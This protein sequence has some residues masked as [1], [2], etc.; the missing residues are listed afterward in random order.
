[1]YLGKM[2]ELADAKTIY[3]RPM[4]PYSKSLLS[5]VPIPDPKIA[6]A[7]KRIMLEGDIPSP[8]NSP[9]GCPFRTRCAYATEKCAAEVPPFNEVEKGHFVA[10]H[11]VT[12]LN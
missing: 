12:E 9:S 8:L 1:M 6:R 7:N 3:N 10:C 5:A 4:H 11:R 2:V